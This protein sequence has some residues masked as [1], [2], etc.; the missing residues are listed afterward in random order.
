MAYQHEVVEDLDLD[1]NFVWQITEEL[2]VEKKA[3]C[4]RMTRT[5]TKEGATIVGDVLSAKRVLSLSRR[6]SSEQVGTKHNG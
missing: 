5:Y 4:D 3:R 6:S 2:R 1:Y